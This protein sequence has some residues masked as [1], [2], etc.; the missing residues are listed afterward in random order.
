MLFREYKTLERFAASKEPVELLI[1][2][3]RL[4]VC[5]D[6]NLA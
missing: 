1:F 6:F 3:L 2:I 4:N 5:L